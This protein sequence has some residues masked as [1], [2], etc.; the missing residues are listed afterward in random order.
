M[1]TKPVELSIR[2]M[3]FLIDYFF[4]MLLSVAISSFF[5]VVF[6][7]FGPN[8]GFFSVFAAVQFFYY[9]I[10]EMSSGQTIGKKIT[11]TKVI[12]VKGKITFLKIFIR[13]F[14]RLIPLDRLSYLFGHITGMHDQYSGTYVVKN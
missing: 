10:F 11:G 6:I 8:S 4:I 14:L 1:N 3:N 12:A 13:T 9:F 7:R 2:L 5:S